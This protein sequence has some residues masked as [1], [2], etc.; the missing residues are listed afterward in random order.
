MFFESCYAV[1]IISLTLLLL[2]VLIILNLLFKVMDDEKEISSQEYIELISFCRRMGGAKTLRRFYSANN[3][4]ISK[5]N[6]RKI[7]RMVRENYLLRLN[8]DTISV[9]KFE[10]KK[11]ISTM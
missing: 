5:K 11:I 6:C 4:V 1:P 10:L 2:V 8:S 7:K 9:N 3:S